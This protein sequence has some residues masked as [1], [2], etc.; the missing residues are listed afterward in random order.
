MNRFLVGLACAV[1][2]VAPAV[3]GDAPPPDLQPIKFLKGDPPVFPYDMIQLGVREGE[4]R[5]AFSVTADGKVDDLL[6]V[7]YTNPEFARVSAGALKRWTFEPAR[8]RGQPIAAVSQV[9]LRFE[10]RGGVIVTLT[11]AESI[12]SML[13]SMTT[14]QDEYRPRTMKEIDRIPTPISAPPPNLPARLTQGAGPSHVTVSFYIDEEGVVRLPSVD[15]A[16]DPELGAAAIDAMRQWKFEPPTCKGRPV[17][18]R[19]SQRFN[20]HRNSPESAPKSAG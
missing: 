4:V 8:Y 20:F 7:F 19:A 2:F 5:I 18:V 6:P 9:T 1:A 13:N 17:L 10:M 16:D 11:A 14:V 15:V 12:A 3:A